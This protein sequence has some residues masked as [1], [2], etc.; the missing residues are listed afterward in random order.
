MG[1]C[2]KCDAQIDRVTIEQIY[3][4]HGDS[5]RG[6]LSYLCPSC[7]CVLAVQLDPLSLKDDVYGGSSEED[8]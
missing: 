6:A 1:I 2:P 5:P 4:F 3:A 7:Q 8:P